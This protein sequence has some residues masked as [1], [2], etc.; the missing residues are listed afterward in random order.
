MFVP[1]CLFL[2][3]RPFNKHRFCKK[4][5]SKDETFAR[6][7]TYESTLLSSR[8]YHLLEHVSVAGSNVEWRLIQPN[9]CFQPF[10]GQQQGV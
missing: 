9:A 4:C 10:F 3:K 7:H 1:D 8:M 6:L 5:F 2:A